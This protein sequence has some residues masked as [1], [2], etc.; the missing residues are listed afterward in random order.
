MDKDCLFLEPFI[1][2]HVRDLTLFE[3]QNDVTEALLGI[4]SDRR[5]GSE[6]AT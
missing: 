5:H 6:T 3:N 1:F 2:V 4:N